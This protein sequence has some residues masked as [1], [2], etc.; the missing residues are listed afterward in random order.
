MP[1]ASLCVRQGGWREAGW[2]PGGLA[3]LARVWGEEPQGEARQRRQ[4]LLNSISPYSSSS[5]LLSSIYFST[6]SPT[7]ILELFR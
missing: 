5:A 7:I 1:G 4:G 3:P 2:G 6:S